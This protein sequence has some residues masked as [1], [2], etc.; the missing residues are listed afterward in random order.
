MREQ[1]H[2]RVESSGVNPRDASRYL[3]ALYFDLEHERR[4]TLISDD[5]ARTIDASMMHISRVLGLLAPHITRQ[6]REA[7]T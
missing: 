1:Q 5:E 7:T 3:L 6:R 2:T 4:T